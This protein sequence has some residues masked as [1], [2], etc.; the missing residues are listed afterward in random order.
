MTTNK[1][2][3]N[4]YKRLL[5]DDNYK[6]VKGESLGWLTAIMYLAPAMSSGVLNVCLGAT[7]WCIALCLNTA[8]MGRFRNVQAARVAKTM[9]LASSRAL[10]LACLRYDIGMYVRR[11]AKRGMRL[12]VRINGTS[13]LPWLAKEMARSF[14]T[15]QFYDYTKLAKAELRQLPNYHITYSYSGENLCESLRVLAQGVNVAVV[16]HVRKGMPLPETWHGYRVIDGDLHDLRFL[17][18]KGVVV[19]LR[20]K[21]LAINADSPFIVLAS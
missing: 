8:G 11:A 18:P 1:R 15:V 20:A 21:G 5:Q 17:D 9:L 3:P 2:K 16:F 10:F 19:G 14:P 13:D 7:A 4:G 12:A 6:T